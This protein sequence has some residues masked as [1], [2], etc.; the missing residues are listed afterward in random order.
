MKRLLLALVG[1]A[2]F[3]QPGLARP[4][5]ALETAL[6]EGAM[7]E[8]QLVLYATPDL[9]QTIAVV[10]DFFQKYPFLDIKVY[11]LEAEALVARV[12]NESH[13]GAPMCDILTG[14]GGLLQPL[15][16]E[17]LLASYQS[18]ERER[19]SET[20]TDSAG[21]WSA[22]FINAYVL[23]YNTLSVKAGEIP[24]S[25]HDL[26]DPRWRGGRIA[27]D[28]T[29]DGLLRGL[30]PTWGEER[31]VGYLKRL[32]GQEPIMSRTSLSA[33]DAVHMGK[34]RLAIARSAV[35]QGYK[36]K[37]R[38][39]V[40]W[41]FLE[42]VVAQAECV[43]ICAQAPHAA[44]ARLFVNFVLSREGQRAL[45]SIEQV[46]VRRDK[47]AP[48]DR[49]AQSRKW[50]VEKPDPHVSFRATAKRFRDIFGTQ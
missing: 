11:P 28:G 12:R 19:I 25:Y 32:A 45:A 30:A 23:V 36:E 38:S 24:K 44:A 9:P 21:F 42:P 26:L 18:L 14:G 40:D 16:Q 50:F 13:A 5:L 43:M 33:V 10:Q 6:L 2:L 8:Q 15:F 39:P 46:P 20:L 17:N 27:I 37:L 3:W 41:T 31:A 48:L 7:K 34:A 1:T 47:D 22:Y 4:R 29:A 49:T 35:V